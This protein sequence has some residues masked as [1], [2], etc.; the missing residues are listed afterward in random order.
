MNSKVFLSD[1]LY[2]MEVANGYFEVVIAHYSAKFTC[3]CIV[4]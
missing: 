4:D 2:Y 1:Y 3:K